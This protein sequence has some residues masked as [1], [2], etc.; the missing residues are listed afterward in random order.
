MNRGR[1]CKG[2]AGQW[3]SNRT[4]FVSLCRVADRRL[5][6]QTPEE[7]GCELE[8]ETLNETAATNEST[9]EALRWRQYALLRRSVVAD[10]GW[11]SWPGWCEVHTWFANGLWEFMGGAGPRV[12]RRAASSPRSAAALFFDPFQARWDSTRA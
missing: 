1:Q 8:N 9:A 2:N 3:G 6:E 5:P 12:S 7:D 4:V 10:V 11:G